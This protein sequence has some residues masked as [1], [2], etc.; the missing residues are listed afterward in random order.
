MINREKRTQS[1]PLLEVDIYPVWSDG[2]RVPTREPKAKPSSEAQKKYND[3]QAVKK[4]VRL[5]NANFDKSDYWM[6]PTYFPDAA[7]QNEQQ[8]RR[9]IVNYIRRVRARREKELAEAKERLLITNTGMGVVRESTDRDK[10]YGKEL[11]KQL[12]EQA[13]ELKK[14]VKKLKRPLKYIYVIEKQ[15]YKTG[16]RAGRANWHFHLFITGGLDD[17]TMEALWND[18]VRVNCDN[19]QPDRFGPE[20]AA[21]YMTKDPQGARRWSCSRNLTKPAEKTRDGRFTRRQ[22]ERIA[23]QRVDEAAWW[24]KQFPGYRFIRCFSRFN[25]YNSNWYVTAVMYKTDQQAPA[26]LEQW[27]ITEQGEDASDISGIVQ[28]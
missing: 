10:R 26:W 13:R 11:L 19:Y 22:V 2:R 7:P 21:R 8:A 9:D 27:S 14:R 24:E 15:T 4:I 5:V 20:A 3:E 16:P 17:K 6:H 23:T 25:E 12:E 18:G 1:G 28:V